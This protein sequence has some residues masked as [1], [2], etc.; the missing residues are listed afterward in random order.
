ML[1]TPFVLALYYKSVFLENVLKIRK[2]IMLI[3]KLVIVFGI[4][5]KRVKLSTD[6]NDINVNNNRIVTPRKSRTLGHIAG[7]V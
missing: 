6:D 7:K 2:I 5:I 3:R 4:L 1:T